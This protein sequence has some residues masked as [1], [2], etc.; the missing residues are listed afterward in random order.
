MSWTKRQLIEQA[1]E[2]VGLASYVY[3]LT[4][5]QLRSALRRLDSMIRTWDSRGI[6]LGY[7]LT[8]L[9][10]ISDLDTFSNIPD[11]ATETTYL[12][13]GI[14]IAPSFGKVVSRDTKAL[15]LSS[16]NALLGDVVVPAEMQMPGTMPAGAGNRPW[17]WNND[18]FLNRPDTSPIRLAANGQLQFT[19]N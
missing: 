17:G 9:P 6:S 15:A 1:F 18:H 16:F 3:D 14:R 12:N 5:D 2:E 7:P 11:S 19:E 4:P 13:L 10:Q 8:T